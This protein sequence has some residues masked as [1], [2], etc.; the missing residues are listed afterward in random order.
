[1]KNLFLLFIIIG[2]MMLKA[3]AQESQVYVGANDPSH[4]PEASFC[5]SMLGDSIPLYDHTEIPQGASVIECIWKFEGATTPELRYDGTRPVVYAT[6]NKTG[7]HKIT[8][9]V[10]V[11]WAGWPT[12]L[13]GEFYVN[14]ASSHANIPLDTM[15]LVHY[16]DR[17]PVTHEMIWYDSVN[18]F[19]FSTDPSYFTW[20][21]NGDM[22]WTDS[23][24]LL[25][26]SASNA[27]MYVVQATSIY[28]AQRDYITGEY[29]GCSTYDT[30]QVLPSLVAT[31]IGEIESQRMESVYPN[32]ANQFG[33]ITFESTVTS[34]DIYDINGKHVLH[35]DQ[36]VIPSISLPPGIYTARIQANDGRLSRTKLAIN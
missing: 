12:D 35:S 8:F 27:A 7:H 19:A 2:M 1:M 25:G 26:M 30:V 32:P 3:E 6:W 11:M 36:N 9:T 29:S 34:I 22:M 15:R 24:S 13:K 21:R 17:N 10:T 33:T 5:N 28:G 4:S 31:G 23:A 16:R 18:L 20:Y 14:I